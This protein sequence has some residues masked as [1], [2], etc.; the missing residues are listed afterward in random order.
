MISRVQGLN[1]DFAKDPDSFKSRTIDD[2]M[3]KKRLSLRRSIDVIFCLI[4]YLGA[5]NSV[6]IGDALGTFALGQVGCAW[7][8]MFIL[9]GLSRFSPR[10]KSAS[11]SR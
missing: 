8:F 11:T 9:R 6:R 2:D 7:Y 3:R 1:V 4:L 5:L 10:T